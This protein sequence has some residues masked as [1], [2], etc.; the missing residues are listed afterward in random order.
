MLYYIVAHSADPDGIIT[1]ALLD[2]A[3]EDESREHYFVDYPDLHETLQKVRWKEPGKVIIADMNLDDVL[4][5]SDTLRKL[6]DRHGYLEWYDHHQ[7]SIRQQE[8]LREYCDPVIVAP[9]FCAAALVHDQYFSGDPYA[10]AL[11]HLAQVHDF[12][13]TDDPR[14]PIAYSL[15][16]I[17]ASG[18]DLSQLVSDLA[19]GKIW[20][21]NQWNKFTPAYQKTLH[22]FNER[23]QE[24]YQRLEDSV[25]QRNIGGYRVAFAFSDP[26]LYMKLAPQHLERKIKTDCVVVLYQGNSNV[27]V[28]GYNH[29]GKDIPTFCNENGGGGRGHAGGFTIDHEV[30]ADSVQSDKEMVAE[31]LERF[32]Q[33]RAA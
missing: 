28:Y 5:N 10:L 4:R 26:L 17:I 15:Q 19:T 6:N 16:D 21:D 14:A 13:R 20:T 27:M 30:T 7:G 23:K 29:L 24:A 18:Q 12:E 1:H 3:L 8:F 22:L 2:R 25:E 33:S 32:F 31:K 11:A 9:N